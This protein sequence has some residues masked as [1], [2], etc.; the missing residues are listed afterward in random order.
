MQTPLAYRHV[1]VTEQ[2]GQHLID[3]RCEVGLYLRPHRPTGA[4]QPSIRIAGVDNTHWDFR[5]RTM[6]RSLLGLLFIAR[7]GS[8][9][10]LSGV[11]VEHGGTHKPGLVALR[12]VAG[13]PR[14]VLPMIHCMRG[15]ICT[16]RRNVIVPGRGHGVETFAGRVESNIF[17]AQLCHW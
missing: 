16:I 15:A 3:M 7:S 10:T 4:P 1:A 9:V 8:N 12:A 5:F 2:H 17:W 11:R 6:S 14:N 13:G